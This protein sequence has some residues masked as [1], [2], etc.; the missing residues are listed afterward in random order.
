MDANGYG[1]LECEVAPGLFDTERNVRFV[2][3]RDESNDEIDI[4]V[5]SGLVRERGQV[6]RGER[7]PGRFRVCVVKQDGP[8]AVVLLPVQNV[9]YGSYVS[10]LANRLAPN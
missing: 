1:W 4:L 5:D 9:K 8:H 2:V 10:V 3:D 7:V 6:K